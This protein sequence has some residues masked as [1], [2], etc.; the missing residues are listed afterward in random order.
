MEGETMDEYLVIKNINGFGE[1]YC[2]NLRRDSDKNK[3][4]N[5]WWYALDFFFDKAFNRGRNDKLSKRFKTFAVEVLKEYFE[6]DHIDLEKSYT[7]VKGSYRRGEFKIN[8]DSPL[9]K[10]LKETRKIKVDYS[11]FGEEIREEKT[12]LKNELDRKLVLSTLDFICKGD[13]KNI[14]TYIKSGVRDGKI[15]EVYTE[16]KKIDGIGDKLAT[17]VIRDVVL[18]NEEDFRQVPIDYKL[19]FPVDTWVR[20]V[21]SK[22]KGFSRLEMR[23]IRNDEIKEYFIK[24]CREYNFWPPRVAAGLWYVGFFSFTILINN[25]DKI[26]I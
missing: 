22:M 21:Y 23:N 5:D 11:I 14:Y 17:F 8:S 24:K 18:L 3:L 25:L 12:C 20:K 4:E 26:S 2:E 10:K 9:Y 16:L 15:E 19:V 6:I 1:E 7:K 13:K